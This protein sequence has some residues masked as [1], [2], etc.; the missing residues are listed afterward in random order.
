MSDSSFQ[1]NKK[2]LI[3]AIIIIFSLIVISFCLTLFVPPGQFETTTDEQGDVVYIPE[4]YMQTGDAGEYPV[5]NI[6]LSVFKSFAPG[7]DV[8]VTDDCD[9]AVHT[10]DRRVVHTA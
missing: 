5:Y 8:N 1:I 7:G 2:S 9:H 4:S 3:T 10:A 6:L